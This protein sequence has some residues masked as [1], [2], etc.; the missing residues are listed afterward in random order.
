MLQ[1]TNADH[2][3]QKKGLLDAMDDSSGIQ[4]IVKEFVFSAAI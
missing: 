2:A 4:H 1:A 3:S